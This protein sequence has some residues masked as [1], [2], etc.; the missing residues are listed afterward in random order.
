MRLVVMALLL[1][2]A[3][4]ARADGWK[5]P[6]GFW[7]ILVK[8]KARWVLVDS[9]E[10]DKRARSKIVVETYDVR[11]VG[12]ADVARLRWTLIEPG[13]KKSD[14]GDSD[15]GRYTQV[16]VTEAGLYILSAD[17]DDAKVAA[18]LTKKPSRSDPPKEYGATK[19]NGGRVLRID[20]RAELVCVGQ[21]PLPGA[22]DCDDVCDADLCISAT[23]GV[24]KLGGMWAPG[25]GLYEAE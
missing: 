3:G 9:L 25:K 2:A 7:R 14:W 15:G 13:G 8:P 11:K 17:M 4:P 12:T 24:V 16:A 18:A 22:G 10:K 19:Q 23:A 6:K 21:D 20:E 1:L 5:P